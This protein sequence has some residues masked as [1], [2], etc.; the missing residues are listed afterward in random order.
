MKILA[1]NGSPRKRRNTA[2]LLSAVLEGASEKGA[3]T[4]LVHLQDLSFKGCASCFACKRLG[5]RTYGRCAQKD[6][7]L[8]VLDKASE[9]DVLVLGTPLYYSLESALL[10][11]FEERLWFQYTRY[12][13]T[14]VTL[15]PPK[16][17]CA[18]VCTMNVAEK[19]LP[20]YPLKMQAIN[21]NKRV[22]ER[23]FSCP[24][25][26]FLSFDTKQFDDYSKY[27]NEMFDPAHK[28]ER[29]R[30][31]FPKELERARALGREL[32]SA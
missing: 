7:L 12:S 8:R 17:A 4:E 6:D 23:V 27:D 20:S 9:A 3:E 11:A 13:T 31:V 21:F 18:Y 22:N 28:E 30:T 26:V 29:F 16:K 24:C 19:D 1:V 10:R 15:A 2:S 32:A 25:H 14:D 5:A